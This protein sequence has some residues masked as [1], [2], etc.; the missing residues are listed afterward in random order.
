MSTTETC[1]YCERKGIVPTDPDDRPIDGVEIVDVSNA[2][3][4]RGRL[5]FGRCPTQYWDSEAARATGPDRL[6]H[7]DVAPDGDPTRIRDGEVE[8]LGVYVPPSDRGVE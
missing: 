3:V 1:D 7:I 8:G 5:K 2:Y 6:S 4:C